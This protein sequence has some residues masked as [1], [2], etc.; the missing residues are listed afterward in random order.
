MKQRKETLTRCFLALIQK[1]STFCTLV[2]KRSL[3]FDVLLF[4]ILFFNKK[5]N[6]LSLWRANI[7]YH[8]N[9]TMRF[10]ELKTQHAL[11]TISQFTLWRANASK[12]IHNLHYG[13]CMFTFFIVFIFKLII[14]TNWINFG[15]LLLRQL[16]RGTINDS[17]ISK[18]EDVLFCSYVR[19]Y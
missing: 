6:N 13:V 7:L 16:I 11:E 9:F 15:S 17:S 4:L 5:L 19:V 8:A 3:I 1:T 18:N 12:Y 10:Y 14:L 2:R